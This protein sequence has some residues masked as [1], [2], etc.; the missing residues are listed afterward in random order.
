MDSPLIYFLSYVNTTHLIT[1]GIGIFAV[2]YILINRPLRKKK[3]KTFWI[4]LA[5][6]ILILYRLAMQPIGWGTGGDRENYAYSIIFSDAASL[7]G[8]SGRTDPLFILLTAIIFGLSDIDGF[9]WGIATIYVGLYF[10][11]AKRLAGNRQLWMFIAFI[12]SLGFLA[13]GYNTIRAGL[14]VS[15]ILLGIT[16]SEKKLPVAIILMV[17]SLFIHMSMIIPISM[18]LISK[19][20]PRPR[21]FFALWIISIPV[22]FFAGDFF[23]NLFTVFSDQ[24]RTQYLLGDTEV[25]KIGFR[26]DFILYSL[27]PLVIGFYYIYRR[28]F[29]SALYKNIYN[30]YVLTNI[31]W[32]L[33]IRSNFTDR[34]AY[35]SW[36]LIPVL[37]VYPLLREPGIV[38]KPDIWLAS[39]IGGETIFSFFF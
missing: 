37:L 23:N 27:V 2:L 7:D 9:F 8:I 28:K 17:L 10:L 26:I 35:L 25:Y 22:S 19:F 18:F 20:F 11:S 24:E 14:A 29:K 32:I 1:L 4:T 13:Y 38:R 31:F 5:I 21:V 34:F 6:G 3:S 15:F 39:I 36:F 16:Y 12:L 30:T 33:V